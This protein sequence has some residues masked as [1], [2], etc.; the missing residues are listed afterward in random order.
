M[1]TPDPVDGQVELVRALDPSQR[2]ET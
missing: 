1:S 2:E